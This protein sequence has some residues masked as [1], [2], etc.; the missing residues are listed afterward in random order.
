VSMAQVRGISIIAHRIPLPTHIGWL[1]FCW[2][3]HKTACRIMMQKALAH[4][5]M[6]IITAFHFLVLLYNM[7][8]SCN[9][10]ALVQWK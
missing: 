6:Q 3:R 5:H 10:W 7:D 1:A 8:Y 2:F 4:L 9:K